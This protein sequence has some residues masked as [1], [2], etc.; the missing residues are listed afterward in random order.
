MT[1][2]SFEFFPP[3]SETARASLGR[4]ASALSVHEPDYVSVTFGAGGSDREGTLATLQMLHRADMPVASHICHAGIGRDDVLAYADEVW[5][6][7]IAELVALRGDACGG[8]AFE[9]TAAFVGALRERHPFEIAVACYPDVHPKASSPQSDI[10]VL[11]AKQDAGATQALSQ[12]FFDCDTFFRFR[13]RAR[14][15][16]VTIPIVPGVLPILDVDKAVAFGEKCGSPVPDPVRER[17]ARADDEA[18]RDRVARE[19]IETQAIELAVGG[20]TGLHVYAL[21]R[22]ELAGAAASAWNEAR[23]Q[24]RPAP[25]LRFPTERR[26]A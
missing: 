24:V 25:P 20:A 23:Q 8:S 1:G 26:A 3:R 17:F 21:N 12:F 5:S 11:L 18:T 22:A 14:R 19:L 6:A 16:G 15:A 7:G 13:D 10:D 9:S 4:V 2:L